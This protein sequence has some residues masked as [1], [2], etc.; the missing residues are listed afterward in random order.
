MVIA[1]K[2]GG[3]SVKDGATL[4]HIIDNIILQDSRR[5][6][7]VL[8]AP[9]KLESNDI[10]V[11]DLLIELG[12][13]YYKSKQYPEKPVEKIRSRFYD[14]VDHFGIERHFLYSQFG[15]L[16][17]AIIKNNS[18]I[19]EYLDGIKPYGEI[20][21]SEIAAEVLRRK[22]INAKVYRPE[23][24]GMEIDGNFGNA[25]LKESSYQKIAENLKPVLEE[26]GEII[27]VPG[28]YG[29]NESGNFTTFQRG[30]SDLSGAILANAVD[31][32]LYENWT[33]KEG[34]LRA[35][36]RI[37]DNPNIIRNMT[38]REA[39]ELAYSGAEILHPDTLIPLIDKGTLLHVRNTFNPRN[40]GTYISSN[41]EPNGNV[42][43]GIAHKQGF[44][45]L[46]ME[47][48]GMNEEI[49]YLS[50]LTKIFDDNKVSIDQIT[51][52]IDSVSIA[53]A[54]NGHNR[55]INAVRDEIINA[56]LV[57]DPNDVEVG[58]DKSLV[59]VVGE[60]MRHTPGVFEKVS[61]ALASKKINIETIYQA[62]ERSIIFGL[63]QKDAVNAVKAIYNLFF[64]NTTK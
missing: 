13:S 17:R 54:S 32:E 4:E 60:G 35:D 18:N 29:I 55:N 59:C 22:G 53:V 23:N 7:I 64:G 5:R 47:K 61:G 33:D 62:S 31:A 1:A 28:F 56:G 37:I 49:G 26:T 38:Y 14:I 41:K 34:I 44:T 36:P 45:V 42:V 3:S 19:D 11:T 50:R 15:S 48:T 21:N 57:N 27:I 24:I 46:Y 9:G 8:S 12:N 58:Y 2:F 6:V 25:K 39:R 30:G 20:I 51:T 10:K 52:G 43:E 40:E 63:D 16:S